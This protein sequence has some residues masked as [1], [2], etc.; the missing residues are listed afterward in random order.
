M[1]LFDVIL[2]TFARLGFRV[3]LVLLPT[4]E[5]SRQTRAVDSTKRQMTAD[6]NGRH[7]EARASQ[8]QRRRSLCRCV[9]CT[10][11]TILHINCL[12]VAARSSWNANRN[13][14]SV[15]IRGTQPIQT[16]AVA[17]WQSGSCLLPPYFSLS[18]NS[19][20]S[21]SFLRIQDLGQKISHRV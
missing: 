10:C 11:Q 21:K 9:L 15:V 19:F 7:R 2:H 17:P 3:L 6:V 8:M 16:S 18:E 1:A 4:Q 20:L 13:V 12:F 14:F 5:C